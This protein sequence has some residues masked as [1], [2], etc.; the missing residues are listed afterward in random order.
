MRDPAEGASLRS[1]WRA[2]ALSG[3]GPVEQLDGLERLLVREREVPEMFVTALAAVIAADRSSIALSAAGHPPPLLLGGTPAANAPGSPPLGVVTGSQRPL[4]RLTL[5]SPASVVLYTD[6]LIE[7][8]A[9]A[10]SPERFGVARVE[11][12]LD[13][14]DPG[15]IDETTL[16]RL[17]DA[18]TTAHGAGLPDDVALLAVNL[19][20]AGWS[21]TWPAEIEAVP[22]L[23]EEVERFAR[24]EGVDEETV[25]A[26]KLAVAEIAS[27][28]VVHGYV[29]RP[30]PGRL[31]VRGDRRGD[32]LH[33]TVADDGNGLRPRSDSPGLGLGLAM[34]AQLADGLDIDTPP[35]GG[36]VVR[37]RFRVRAG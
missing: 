26:V 3:D 7:G 25:Y 28:A 16:G 36:T 29:G 31:T 34:I 24:Q 1:A 23:R 13:G 19:T 12:L 5:G 11:A 30:L 18:A 2:L 8:R 32:T 4:V 35:G 10:G 21:G 20:P 9:Q 22:E 14:A 37:L 17:V 33:V 6:G 27:N 15:D